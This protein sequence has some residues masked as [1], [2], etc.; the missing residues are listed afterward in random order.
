MSMKHSEVN[1]VLGF[2]ETNTSPV[3]F[4]AIDLD[5]GTTD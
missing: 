5:V 4:E 3:L 1:A 2:R